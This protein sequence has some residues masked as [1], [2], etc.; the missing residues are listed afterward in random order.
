MKNRIVKHF[1]L[2]FFLLTIIFILTGCIDTTNKVKLPNLDKMTREQIKTEMEKLGLEYIFYFDKRMY[3]DDSEFDQ[4]VSY[5]H[6]KAGNYVDKNEIIYIYT[7]A[8]PLTYHISD[9]VKLDVNYDGKEFV[10]DGIGKVTLARAIDGDTAHFYSNGKYIKVRFLG[11]D[12]PESTRDKQA[13]GK[14]ASNYTKNILENA[15]E[16]VLESEGSRTDVY[17]RYLAYVWVDGVL[18]NLQLVEN[19][20]T[21]AKISTNKKYGSIF[22]E[23]SVEASRTGRRIYGEIDPD[24]DYANGRFK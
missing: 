7:T 12:T 6:Y 10:K 21:T 24:Y 13:W 19:A 3:I 16:I 5:E 20:Y 14:A 11:I 4:F 22:M 17:E 15:K 9:K 18:L 1:G 2:I 8:L 23:A